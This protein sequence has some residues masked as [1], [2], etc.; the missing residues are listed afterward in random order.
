MSNPSETRNAGIATVAV[1]VA[2]ALAGCAAGD[3]SASATLNKVTAAGVETAPLGTA[4]ITPSGDSVEIVVRVSAGS[5]LTAGN[6]GVHVHANG[7]CGPGAASATNSTVIAAGAAGGHFNP[8]NAKHGRHAGDLGNIAIAA[9]GSGE[10]RVGP[11][12]LQAALTLGTGT[13]S[14]AGKSVVVHAAADD[15]TTDPSGNSGGRVLCG[16]IPS[17]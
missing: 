9:D 10:L 5:G 13:F 16:V 8:T 12:G 6:H 7:A 17:G 15:L 11:T 1:A 4:T 14:I 3:S 2:L